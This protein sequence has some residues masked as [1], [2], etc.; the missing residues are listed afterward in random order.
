MAEKIRRPR[1]LIGAPEGL[2]FELALDAE[3]P[4]GL[5]WG[6]CRVFLAG[7]PVWVGEDP[8][9]TEIPLQWTWVD[10]LEFLGRA[11]PWLIAEED[12]PLPVQPLYPALFLRE[13]ERR[14]E[15]LSEAQ[16]EEEEEQAHRFL[17]RHDLAAAMKGLFLPAVLLLRQGNTGHISAAALRQTRVRPWREIQTTLEMVGDHLA[18]ACADSAQPRAQQAYAAWRQRDARLAQREL[19]LATGLTHDERARFEPFG[20]TAG[21]WM[22][23]EI[24]AVARM[25]RG[26][27]I[28][29][30]QAALL[31]QVVRSPHLATPVLDDLAARCRSAFQE[32]GKP[33]EQG[34]GLASWLRTELGI[35]EFASVEPKDWLERWNVRVQEIH[36]ESCPIE[37][38]TAWGEQ[39]GPVI[40]LNR[41]EGCRSAHQYGARATLAHEIAHLI[42]DRDAALPAGEVL[43]GRTPEYP[44]KRARAFAAEFLFPRRLAENAIRESNTLEEAV[45]ILQGEH[46]VSTELLAWQIYNSGVRPALTEKET[47]LLDQWRTGAANLQ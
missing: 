28:P 6:H 36:L 31:A 30:H 20:V 40:L 34:Y 27:V 29:E 23:P 3:D 45:L 44:E 5:A 32:A 2:Q 19:D 18:A 9:G 7:E 1:R 22:H 21:Q 41:A 24:R 17:A 10:L 15:D 35:D 39:H 47:I 42:L 33:H 8:D 46:R 14:W 38:V 25:T 37:A 16:V 26:A 13:A 4:R 12:Y 11:W 43:G